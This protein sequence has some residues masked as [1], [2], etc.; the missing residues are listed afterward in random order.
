MRRPDVEAQIVKPD[1]TIELSVYH[2]IVS[3]AL[4]LTP[5]GPLVPK[6]LVPPMVMPSQQL[7]VSN[8]VEV[9]ESVTPTL[10][11]IVQRSLLPWLPVPS[12]T[13]VPLLMIEQ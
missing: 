12:V 1:L 10:A 8:E 6:Y 11:V 2:D 7:S 9:V 13:H 5:L 4:M 3:P